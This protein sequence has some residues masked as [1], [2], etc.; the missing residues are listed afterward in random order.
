MAFLTDIHPKTK[1]LYAVTTGTYVGEMFCYIKDDGINYK[2]IS[3]PKNI[4][5]EIPKTKFKFALINKI[6]EHVEQLPIDVYTVLEAQYQYNEKFNNRREQSD[7][8]C[9]LDS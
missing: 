1:N 7:T 8:P 2:F 6:V 9:V 5:R 4:N 3:I